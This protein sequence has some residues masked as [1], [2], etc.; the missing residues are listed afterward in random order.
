MITHDVRFLEVTC[1]HCGRSC[2]YRLRIG[3]S[4]AEMM[5]LM[6]L[7]CQACNRHGNVVVLGA[8]TWASDYRFQWCNRDL[9]AKHKIYFRK[10]AATPP[11]HLTGAS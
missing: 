4:V 10:T 3:S 2:R 8:W 5:L 11:F 9:R 6:T 1:S 7:A